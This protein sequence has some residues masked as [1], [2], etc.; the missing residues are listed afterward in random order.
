MI[1]GQIY[2]GD[3]LESSNRVLTWHDD[4]SF[5]YWISS[6]RTAGGSQGI[7][8]F[9]IQQLQH[10]RKPSLNELKSRLKLVQSSS[11]NPSLITAGRLRKLPLGEILVERARLLMET[12]QRETQGQKAVSFISGP[13]TQDSSTLIGARHRVRPAILGASS[14][15]AIFVAKVYV[16]QCKISTARAAQRTADYLGVNAN[17]VHVALKIARRNMWL[18]SFGSGKAGGQL[19]ELGVQ[20]FYFSRGPEREKTIFKERGGN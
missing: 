5:R 14:D 17:L 1:S 13:R 7:Q 9:E 19:T 6:F 18:T 2:D 12:I 16:D 15:D 10:S 8:S 4:Q 11:D 20:E 3:S